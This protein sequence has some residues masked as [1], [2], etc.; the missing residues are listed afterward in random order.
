MVEMLWGVLSSGG[1][2]AP[3]AQERAP[4]NLV[5]RL[6]IDDQVEQ[7]HSKVPLVADEGVCRKAS[8]GVRGNANCE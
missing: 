1:A 4:D 8:V 3:A 7:A 6:E 5:P 2:G